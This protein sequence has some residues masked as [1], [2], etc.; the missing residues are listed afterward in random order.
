MYKSELEKDLIEATKE[1]TL[2]PKVEMFQKLTLAA[3][4]SNETKTALFSLVRT[5]LGQTHQRIRLMCLE[6]LD[7]LGCVSAERVLLELASPAMQKS[8]I[9]L[10]ENLFAEELKLKIAEL[11]LLWSKNH[12]DPKFDS[13]RTSLKTLEGMGTVPQLKVSKYE[14]Y[15]K[16]ENA[17]VQKIITVPSSL[18]PFESKLM[19]GL[20]EIDA[21]VFDLGKRKEAMSNDIINQ[22]FRFLE[23]S[24]AKI[25]Q[26]LENPN[27]FSISFREYITNTFA[28]LNSILPQLRKQYNS[29]QLE[30]FPEFQV[31][32]PSMQ[33]QRQVFE[34]GA[35]TTAKTPFDD[36]EDEPRQNQPPQQGLN[37]MGIKLN[38]KKDKS[39]PENFNQNF[40]FDFGG[41]KVVGQP[42]STKQPEDKNL[43]FL[44]GDHSNKEDFLGFESEK[45]QQRGSDHVDLLDFDVPSHP[46]QTK[47]VTKNDNLFDLQF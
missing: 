46:V 26:M 23:A 34:F 41:N 38:I 36:V 7:F 43:D 22:K 11:L 3:H 19:V 18:N 15:P 37:S 35:P 12:P 9:S 39:K 33:N 20:R 40:A 1:T 5:R 31:K 44:S 29:Q 17:R 10:H 30:V 42:V 25:A 45:V 2:N 8:L 47:K 27:Q 24:R 14:G 16:L 28:N 4:E 32:Q 21:H 6:F 13:F